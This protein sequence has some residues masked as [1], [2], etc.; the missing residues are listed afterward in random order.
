MQ[1]S[2]AMLFRW[3]WKI[4]WNLVANLSKTLHINFYQNRLRIVEIM[5][6]NKLVCFLCLTVYK[7]LPNHNRVILQLEIISYIS[8]CCNF[9]RL[10]PN[11]IAKYGT[12]HAT[13]IIVE[14]QNWSSSP[15]LFVQTTKLCSKL[16]YIGDVYR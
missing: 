2:V 15:E 14:W 12:K 5:S 7:K 1:D 13:Y 8:C 10:L 6:Q 9:A 3:S 11:Y 16:G 4:L